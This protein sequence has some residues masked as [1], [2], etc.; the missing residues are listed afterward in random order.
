MDRVSN[1]RDRII[2]IASAELGVREA[3]GNNDGPRVEEYLG[4]THLGSGY[5]WCASFI[6]WV[7]AQ[8]GFAQPRN[9]WSPALFPKARVYWKGGAFVQGHKNKFEAA[10]VF[11]IYGTTAKRINHVGLVKV[12][13][14]NYLISIEGNSNNRVESRR[15]H[16]RTIYAL[17]DWL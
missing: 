2:A 5:A 14:G 9:P 6:S 12:M 11:G 17:A 3:T 4:Y 8:A 7:Y 1:N 10:D 15:R 16:V 13:Q